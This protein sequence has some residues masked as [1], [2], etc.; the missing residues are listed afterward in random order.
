MWNF[1]MHQQF[2]IVLLNSKKKNPDQISN[3]MCAAYWLSA[4]IISNG[5]VS[6]YRRDC[7]R[8]PDRPARTDP[9]AQLLSLRPLHKL[10]LNGDLF[11]PHIADPIF[12]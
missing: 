4:S 9:K 12:L 2:Y 10:I 1:T 8:V 5:I 11:P 3:K 7:V 6:Q